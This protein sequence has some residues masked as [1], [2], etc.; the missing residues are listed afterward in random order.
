MTIE[1]NLKAE[2]SVSALYFSYVIYSY[3]IEIALKYDDSVK[4]FKRKK[5]L[6][7]K[8]VEMEINVSVIVPFY[9]RSELFLKVLQSVFTQS[10]QPQEIILL[11]G[12]FEHPEFESIHVCKKQT[13]ITYLDAQL[14]LEEAR[15]KGAELASGK[16]ITFLEP[17]ELWM[18]DKL[19]DQYE[20][21]ESHPYAG[22][23][24]GGC[25]SLDDFLYK[26]KPELLQANDILFKE[27]KQLTSV[28]LKTATYRHIT[29]VDLAIPKL[30]SWDLCIQLAESG[31]EQHC[32]RHI[33]VPLVTEDE[34]ERDNCSHLFWHEHREV[35]KKHKQ[36]IQKQLG[37]YGY[38]FLWYRYLFIAGTLRGNLSGR[39]I[40]IYAYMMKILSRTTLLFDFEAN[41]VTNDN[42]I[43]KRR[44]H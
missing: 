3:A 44:L 40:M 13:N 14:S 1:S 6:L 17:N 24:Y 11:E 12:I 16:Y 4:D 2:L 19:K 8:E 7:N 38:Y 35:L 27:K 5:L 30:A 15:Q 20:F 31:Y 21:M 23:V 9:S 26:S 25:C 39:A 42:L 37:N 36:L 43:D 22:A 28:M 29:G 10:A 32:L 33:S 18:V 34:S 41:S